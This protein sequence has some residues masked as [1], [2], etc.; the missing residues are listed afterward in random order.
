[1][2]RLGPSFAQF[3]AEAA[4]YARERSRRRAAL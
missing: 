2:P 3:L 1:L 4:L